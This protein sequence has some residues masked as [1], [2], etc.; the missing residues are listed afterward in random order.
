MK[1]LVKKVKPDFHSKR[2]YGAQH[3]ASP[4][5]KGMVGRRCYTALQTYFWV[6]AFSHSQNLR[7]GR[8]RPGKKHEVQENVA[9]PWPAGEN[10]RKIWPI[11]SP[12]ARK[13][14]RFFGCFRQQARERRR[15]L[16]LCVF[17][18]PRAPP[19][20]QGAS[21]SRSAG[22]AAPAGLLAQAK[23]GARGF[24]AGG[25]WRFALW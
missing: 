9:S 20:G 2:P 18:V 13:W 1:K 16:V 22:T 8:S 6:F 17:S 19:R 25:A 4:K 7:A 21:L 15:S 24:A 12:S 3:G 14:A 11:F 23:G 10:I 5:S